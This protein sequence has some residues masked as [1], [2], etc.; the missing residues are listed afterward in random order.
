MIQFNA[1]QFNICEV[2]SLFVWEIWVRYSPT[3]ISQEQT[4]E[5]GQ[6]IFMQ[7]QPAV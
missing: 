2:L 6:S 1:P 5:K 4:N 3:V 7:I